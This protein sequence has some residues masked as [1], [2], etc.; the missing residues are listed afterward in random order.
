MSYGAFKDGIGRYMFRCDIDRA[1][2]LPL[3]YSTT[4]GTAIAMM[5]FS[6]LPE[7]PQCFLPAA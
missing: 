4:L 5:N 7:I 2:V 6:D 3:Q 1:L